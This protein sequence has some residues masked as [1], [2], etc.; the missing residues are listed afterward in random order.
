[1]ILP[2]F[3]EKLAWPLLDWSAAILLATGHVLQGI[4]SDG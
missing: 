4:W 3:M 1:M 2:V